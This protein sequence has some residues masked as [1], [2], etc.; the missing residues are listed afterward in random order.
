MQVLKIE[1]E[2]ITTSFRY[3][4]FMVGKQPTFPMPPPATIYGHI[5]SALGEW[6]KP[7]GIEFGY[8]FTHSGLATDL[9][10]FHIVSAKSG[11]FDWRG[12][13]M[14]KNLEGNVNPYR[15]EFFFKPRL[16]L[17]INRP[18]WIEAFRS[19]RY[20]VLLGRSQDLATYT[21]VAVVELYR[22]NHAYY[23]HTL[24]RYDEWRTRIGR[25]IVMT[26]PRFLDYHRTRAPS[27]DQYIVL[28][29]RIDTKSPRGIL[30]YES[31]P[32]HHWVDPETNEIN[33][34]H[35]GVMF[36]RFVD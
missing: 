12:V 24:F 34:C 13:K 8:V 27:F 10:H 7:E 3:P 4:H 26:L 23:E 5:C 2:G 21:R 17:Y 32:T 22:D 15:R 30:Q 16:T 25:G 19:P 14:K 28:T 20:P 35:R 18:E 9:E 6:V 29:D 1:L 33:D 31:Q 36:H 11:T